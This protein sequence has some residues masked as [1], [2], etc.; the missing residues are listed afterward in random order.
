HQT[1][2][3]SQ[4]L[5]IFFLINRLSY[6]ELLHSDVFF[7]SREAKAFR[8][9]GFHSPHSLHAALDPAKD[10]REQEK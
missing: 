8:V 4:I 6:E 10:G 2:L 5:R 7:Q 1:H 3:F 9:S